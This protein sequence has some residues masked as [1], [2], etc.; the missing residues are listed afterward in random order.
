[1]TKQSLPLLF[2]LRHGSDSSV[3]P[4][5]IISE[6]CIHPCGTKCK[7]KGKSDMRRPAVIPQSV[8]SVGG[9]NVSLNRSPPSNIYIYIY[10]Y[11]HIHTYILAFQERKRYSEC[12]DSLLKRQAAKSKFRVLDDALIKKPWRN[13]VSKAG[14]KVSLGTVFGLCK[15]QQGTRRTSTCSSPWQN[16]I[17]PLSQCFKCIYFV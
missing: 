14:F 1:M 7:E 2:E 16:G 8:L 11:I 9:G 12:W 17:Y 5:A 15:Q 4:H 10:I 13:K 6:I 3:T